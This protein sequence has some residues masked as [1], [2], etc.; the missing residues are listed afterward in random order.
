MCVREIN[1]HTVK[2]TRTINHLL[3]LNRKRSIKTRK[4]LYICKMSWQAK[5]NNTIGRLI[6]TSRND[7]SCYHPGFTWTWNWEFDDHMLLN[8]G[9]R[10]CEA[11][12]IIFIIGTNITAINV[13]FLSSS[14]RFVLLFMYCI[15]LY[16]IYTNN[17]MFNTSGL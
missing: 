1:L 8:T 2:Y 6:S 14:S 9:I 4:P 7:Q 17:T 16:C 13:F 11:L 10:L 15:V 5:K 3:R 12:E